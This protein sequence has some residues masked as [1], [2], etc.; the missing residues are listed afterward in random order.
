M[1]ALNGGTPDRI[2]A[3]FWFHFTGE[4][5]SGQSAID[6]HIDYFRQCGCDMMKIMSDS[7]FDYA[8][9]MEVKTPADWYK[10]KPLGTAH[11]FY[12]GQIERARE[13]AKAVRK[14]VPVYYTVFAPFSSI[15][16]LRRRACDADAQRKSRRGH[17]R[18][19]RHHRGYAD[20]YESVV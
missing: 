18:T 13:I 11:P 5:A 3:A 15:L 2:P 7:Y 8:A 12:A 4:K 19:G 1:T 6:A 17:A 14:D 9:S 10:L 16:R 20:V